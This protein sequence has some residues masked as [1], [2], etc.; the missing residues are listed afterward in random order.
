MARSRFIAAAPPRHEASEQAKRI[1]DEIRNLLDDLLRLVE[2]RGTLRAV[3]ISSRRG[4][5]ESWRDRSAGSSAFSDP[6]FTD[7]GIDSS[8]EKEAQRL[9]A[10]LRQKAKQKR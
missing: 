10:S 3:G 1:A 6:T 4:K 5:E 9:L 7:D 2:E 8:S